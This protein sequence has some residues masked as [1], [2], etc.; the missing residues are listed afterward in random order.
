MFSQ[1]GKLQGFILDDKKNPVNDVNITIQ[2]LTS[3]S[4]WCHSDD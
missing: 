3:Q 1:K 2:G 4:P